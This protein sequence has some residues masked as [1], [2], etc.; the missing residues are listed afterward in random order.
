MFFGKE[1]MERVKDFVILQSLQDRRR[2]LL[3][4]EIAKFLAR[5]FGRNRMLEVPLEG[6]SKPF[7][8]ARFQ[9]EAHAGGIAHGAQQANR[10]IRETVYRKRAHLATLD[11]G[12][13]VRGIEQ[14]SARGGIQ[15]DGDGVE[16]EV[17]PAQ[18]LHNR[19]PA[20]FG[21][22]ARPDVVIAAARDDYY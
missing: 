5:I 13:D 17:A 3:A 12:K 14:Q 7:L 11:N 19:R 10:L 6:E 15:S 18:K 21:S 8:C 4:R 2:A 22:G 16:R 9:F 1:G 20:D